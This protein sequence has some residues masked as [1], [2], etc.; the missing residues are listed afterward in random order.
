MADGGGVGSYV[1]GLRAVSYRHC[2]VVSSRMTWRQIWSYSL[3][4]TSDKSGFGPLVQL[5]MYCHS[6]VFFLK[7]TKF[8]F[9]LIPDFLV[10]M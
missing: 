8:C 1:V 3:Q 2:R 10:F 7:L 6:T 4:V 5:L 9:F